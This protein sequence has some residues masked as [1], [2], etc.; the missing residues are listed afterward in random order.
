MLEP[1]NI[2][3][4]Q[5]LIARGCSASISE[6]YRRGT[7]TEWQKEREQRQEQ[8]EGKKK[9]EEQEQ[10]GHNCMKLANS[11]SWH[12]SGNFN[13]MRGSSHSYKEI[14]FTQ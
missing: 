10:E 8:K 1:S 5:Y 9:E 3:K 14:D 7:R 6:T 4:V 2:E 11:L 12:S 13:G